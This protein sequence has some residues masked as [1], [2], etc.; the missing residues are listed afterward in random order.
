M[1]FRFILISF[2]LINLVN[3]LS[4]FLVNLNL[5]KKYVPNV[6]EMVSSVCYPEIQSCF[7]Q[8]PIYDIKNRRLTFYTP[9]TPLKL[10]LR[11]HLFNRVDDDI[12]KSFNFFFNNLTDQLVN[13]IQLSNTAHTLVFIPGWTEDYADS[14]N[15]VQS[16]DNWLN[17]DNYQLIIVDWSE[18]S[19][20]CSYEEAVTNSKVIS[21]VLSIFLLQLNSK[22]KINLAKT[23]LVGKNLGAHIAGQ[24]GNELNINKK[25]KLFKITAFDPPIDLFEE[26][27]DVD[28]IDLQDADHVEVIH[29]NANR[30]EFIQNSIGLVDIFVFD[31]FK[32]NA[33][34]ISLSTNQSKL[35][36]NTEIDLR[37]RSALKDNLLLKNEKDCHLLAF[38]CDSYQ[39]FLDGKCSVCDNE[40][41][42]KLIGLWA[43]QLNTKIEKPNKPIQ[44]YSIQS[45]D[46]TT[47]GEFLI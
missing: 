19:L 3:C 32:S 42:C 17:K 34:T 9:Q 22:T 14:K 23:H 2:L 38:K 25:T 30:K 36:S 47:C 10:N 37:M 8:N 28:K 20:K 45:T 4:N 18:C 6:P 13:Q 12:E 35:S 43:N 39:N 1:L 26:R 33:Q 16:L 44:Y 27:T 7:N 5:I 24:V 31:N 15:W 46:K 21:K 40:M 29:T 41:N 11:F